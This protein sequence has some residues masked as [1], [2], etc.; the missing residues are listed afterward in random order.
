MEAT[1]KVLNA[2]VADGVVEKYAI[3][4]AVA[5]AFW[6]EPFFTE[7]LDIFVALPAT[8]E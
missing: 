8:A 4:G 5:A 3:G 7:D 2:L 6:L 1:I